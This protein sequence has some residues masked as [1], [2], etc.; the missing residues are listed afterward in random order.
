MNLS[1]LVQSPLYASQKQLLLI[2]EA[3]EPKRF[4]VSGILA[5]LRTSSSWPTPRG[6]AARFT[7]FHLDILNP[8]SCYKY[9]GGRNTTQRST[10]TSNPSHALMAAVFFPFAAANMRRF[11]G[12][13]TFHMRLIITWE[14]SSL[15]KG[16]SVCAW[17]SEKTSITPVER[18]QTSN[19]RCTGQNLYNEINLAVLQMKRMKW[20][21][22]QTNNNVTQ[23]KSE[24]SCWFIPESTNGRNK[25]KLLNSLVCFLLFYNFISNKDDLSQFC[26]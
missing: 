18:W 25:E 5:S 9:S 3:G 26:L 22:A 16:L 6:K 8:I 23:E 7:G 13:T 2:C 1:C 10:L 11:I 12:G 24:N 4:F 14:T 19:L 20:M 15:S 17:D 21:Y